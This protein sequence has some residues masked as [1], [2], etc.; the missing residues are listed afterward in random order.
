MTILVN[1]WNEEKR[2]W[3]ERDATITRVTKVQ[4]VVELNGKELRF[5]RHSG[6][7]QGIACNQT[8]DIPNHT[9]PYIDATEL[10]RTKN[11]ALTNKRLYQ[12]I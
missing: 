8:K 7:L 11:L 10:D 1:V 9:A 6:L 4:L 12:R 3:D 5:Y 2:K